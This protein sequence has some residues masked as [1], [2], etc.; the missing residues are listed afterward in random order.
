VGL[1]DA[2]VVHRLLN[3][4]HELYIPDAPRRRLGNDATF[5]L[6]LSEIQTE[7]AVIYRALTRPGTQRQVHGGGDDEVHRARV[8]YTLELASL[9][10]AAGAPHPQWRWWA[11]QAANTLLAEGSAQSAA[12]W[13][14]VAHDNSLLTHL[15]MAPEPGSHPARVVW[16]LATASAMR[17]P[18]Q[19]RLVDEFDDFNAAWA[20]LVYSIPARDHV[21]TGRCLREITDFWI[22]EDDDWRNFHPRSYPDFEPELNAA[23]AL[24]RSSGWEP[25]AWP[26]DAVCFLEAGIAPGHLA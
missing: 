12:V 3:R 20:S 7:L 22:S 14:V 1:T 9:L 4:A 10:F 2:E 25:R 24:A 19:P 26:E 23:A 16:W 6:A 5:Q 21:V 18:A 13:A 11:A 8:D 15:P 17:A